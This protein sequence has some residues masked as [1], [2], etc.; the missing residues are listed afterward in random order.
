ETGKT[1]P[2]VGLFR[3]CTFLSVVGRLLIPALHLFV[4]GERSALASRRT[5]F[6]LVGPM[7]YG[8]NLKDLRF[9][10]G[11]SM[12]VMGLGV[13]DEIATS[14]V[15]EVVLVVVLFPVDSDWFGP[16]TMFPAVNMVEAPETR[17]SFLSLGAT[18]SDVLSRLFRMG[19]SW[20]RL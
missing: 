10:S 12:C 6:L 16:L 19:Q 2:L 7:V 1:P 13:W 18:R 3:R 11:G 5:L 15:L 8:S 14:V 9:V 4:E 17:V 20:A